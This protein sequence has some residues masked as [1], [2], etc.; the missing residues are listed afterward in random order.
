[1]EDFGTEWQ[2]RV[3]DG[4]LFLLNG[5]ENT[6]Y[7]GPRETFLAAIGGLE[8][9]VRRLVFR[10]R[11]GAVFAELYEVPADPVIRIPI[12]SGVAGQ[13]SVFHALEENVWRW[14]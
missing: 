11:S 4:G 3:A 8:R 14:S 2:E 12:A 5:P 13:L 9:P 7:T 10:Q 1:M 6:F